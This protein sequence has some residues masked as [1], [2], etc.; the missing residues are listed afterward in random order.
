MMTSWRKGEEKRGNV[1]DLLE[2]M[3]GLD[4]SNPKSISKNRI[5]DEKATPKARPKKRKRG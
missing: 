4:H 2:E 5:H 3:P 1:H